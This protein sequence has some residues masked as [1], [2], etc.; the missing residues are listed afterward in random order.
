ME[1]GAV[2]DGA[3]VGS[4][5][6]LERAGDADELGFEGGTGGADDGIAVSTHVDEGGVGGEG[7]VRQG[8]RFGEV[9]GFLVFEAGADAVA[10]EE[11]D[12]GLR[13][14]VSG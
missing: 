9:A 8:A 1:A 2:E 3:A 5:G 6:A 10:Q 11:V 7:R 12:G 4:E 13:T 14:G